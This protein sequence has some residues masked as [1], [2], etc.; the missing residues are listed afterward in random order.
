MDFPAGDKFVSKSAGRLVRTACLWPCCF[1][2]PL[3]LPRVGH[4]HPTGIEKRAGTSS[5]LNIRSSSTAESEKDMLKQCSQQCSSNARSMGI[6]TTALRSFA[7]AWRAYPIAFLICGEFARVTAPAKTACATMRDSSC[8]NASGSG[9][10][11]PSPIPIA[12]CPDSRIR[13]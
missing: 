9:P 1:L 2:R 12:G 11:R 3:S 6:S 10:A 8:H 5:R 13:G 4:G 7:C